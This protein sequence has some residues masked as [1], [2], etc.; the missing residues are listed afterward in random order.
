ME[1]SEFIMEN[2]E[3]VIN[4]DMHAAK[5]RM[6]AKEHFQDL[7]KKEVDFFEFIKK[8]AQLFGFRLP[9]DKSE[10]FISNDAA[11]FYWICDSPAV[12]KFEEW[13]KFEARGRNSSQDGYRSIKEFYTK[14]ATLKSEQEKKYYALSTMKMIEKDLNKNNILVRVLQAVILTYDKKL[15]HPVK[16]IELFQ[17]AII[18]LDGLKVDQQ[19]KNELQ[20][21]LNIYTGFAYLK[22]LDYEGA[23]QMFSEAMRMSLSGLTARFYLAFSEKRSGSGE[24][25][26]LHL[27][28]ILHFDKTAIEYAIE[29]NSPILL[30]YFIKNAVTYNIFNELEFADLL[31]HIEAGLSAETG[32]QEY[33]FAKLTDALGRLRDLKL[34]EFYTEEVEKSIAFLETVSESL[35]GNKNTIAG[36]S[37]SL[38]Q[39]KLF[40]VADSIVDTIQKQYTAEI[41]DQLKQYDI[42]IGENLEAI[43]HLGKE[44][45]EIKKLQRKK[46]EDALEELDRMISENITIL[47]SKIENIHQNKKFNP[48][49]VFNNSM[50][51][52]LVITMIVFIIGGFSGC[53]R[54]TTDDVSTFRDVMSTVMIA[55]F[56]WGA[57]IFL[58]G[59]IISAFTA[60]FAVM[61]RTTEKQNLLRKITYLKAHKERE[62]EILMRENEKKIK[63]IG[64]NFDVRI[65]EHKRSVDRLK[66]EKDERYTALR[67]SADRK[68]DAYKEKLDGALK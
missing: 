30:T 46:Y 29:I 23:S 17:N 31:D 6:F 10:L 40:K 36:F 14:W 44:A 64:D 5:F 16:A 61:E 65:E 8:S 51:Y 19:V 52:N 56:K 37:Q 67:E 3:P 32:I 42:N 25:A 1:P 12:V 49:A 34:G 50:V 54:G 38:L 45:E 27:N 63:A 62:S 21:L 11:P 55:G 66:T 57:I 26:V 41:N 39:N 2:T 35:L 20:Y 33:S 15:F 68:L 48:Q 9:Q 13:L 4:P 47:E 59:T 18:T 28:D 24:A 43:K 22:Q 53:Y 60:A 58:L 7:V